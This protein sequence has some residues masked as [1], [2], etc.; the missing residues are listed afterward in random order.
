MSGTPLITTNVE[1][2]A[3]I[4]N[5]GGLAGIPTETVYGLGA[6][7]DLRESVHR[8]FDVKGR[9]RTHPLIAHIGEG[10]DVSRWAHF[11]ETAKA[12][13]DRF[14]PGPLTLLLPKTDHV[15]SWVTGGRDTVGLRMP[16]HQMTLKLL[17]LVEDA[18]VAPSA[19]RFGKVSPTTAQHVAND[20]G[21]DVDCIL[22]GG[23]CELGLESTIVECVGTN[24]AVLRP[25]AVSAAQISDVL[26]LAVSLDEG[27]SRA[28]GMMVSHYAP[29]A[30]VRLVNS[31]DEAL[32]MQ[33]DVLITSQTSRVLHYE[34]T[35]QYAVHLYDFLR[36][37]DF[38]KVHVVIAVMPKG[39]GIATAIRD[40]L[41]KAAAKN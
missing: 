37:C 32:A 13:A 20:L 33:H 9:P 25:G 34:D 2:V 14:W 12:L 36:Q 23:H 26:G 1:Y 5:D 35:D 40:R 28:P 10:A 39:G 27:E 11:N 8:I 18:I 19:N 6:R 41:L 31:L 4:L 22:D 3:Q 24:I 38:D 21:S 16:R 17:S 15:G 29:S 30:Q 7:A